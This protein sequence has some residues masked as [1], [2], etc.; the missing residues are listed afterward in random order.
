MAVNSIQRELKAIFSADVQGYSTLMGEDDEY[1]AKTITAY[2]EMVADLIDQHHGRVVDAPGD[3]ILAEFGSSLNAVRGAIEIQRTLNRKNA[4]LPANRRMYFRIGIN[5]GDILRIDDRIYGDGVNIAAR[6]ESLAEPGGIC[7]SR[8]VHEHIDGKLDVNFIDLGPHTV[9]NIHKPV[10]IYKMLLD[11][12]DAGRVVGVSSAK[13]LTRRWLVV[14][15]MVLVVGVGAVGIWY[16]QTK[17]EFA[18]ASV[19]RHTVDLVQAVHA[20]SAQRAE[21]EAMAAASFRSIE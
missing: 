14:A 5:L 8:G 6:I 16:H 11:P 4:S 20:T 18:P 12:K 13:A 17:P 15:V 9:K 7:I 2:R 21:E 3:N 1:T 19:D 10:N